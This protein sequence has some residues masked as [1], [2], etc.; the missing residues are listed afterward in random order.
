MPDE[1]L[2]VDAIDAGYGAMPILRQVSLR[3]G[4]DESV[5]II[6]ANGAGKS[7]LVRAICGLLPI[8][9]GSISKSGKAVGAMAPHRRVQEG[10]GVVLENRHLFG[11][12]TV[13]TNLQI[14][15]LQGARRHVD[16]AYTLD[17][18]CAL[19]PFMRERLDAPV[20]L[21]SGGEQQMVAIARALLLQPDL[22]IM[23]EPSTGL[24]PKILRHIAEA[25]AQLRTR[26][27]GILLV[28]QNVAL[29]AEIAD[30]AYVMSLGRII[31]EI[32]PGQWEGIMRDETVL[33][34]YLGG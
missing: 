10:I 13:R 14:A 8:T 26:G 3:V 1:L 29:A 12:L 32:Q 4:T 23:D 9:S 22:L 11:E 27:M 7:T 30:R 20:E 6:G 18:V 16:R 34:A 28:E 31:H 21:L 5:A 15:Q 24:A 2:R 19:F 25:V 17:D 33:Q